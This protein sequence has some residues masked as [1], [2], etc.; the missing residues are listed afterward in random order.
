M[1]SVRLFPA[2]P[3]LTPYDD[4]VGNAASNAMCKE[5]GNDVPSQWSD[6]VLSALGIHHPMWLPIDVTLL[7]RRDGRSPLAP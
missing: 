5:R 6:D 4:P 7:R 1:C 3:P 2:A